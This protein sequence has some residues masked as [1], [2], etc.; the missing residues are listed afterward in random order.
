MNSELIKEL[1]IALK[2][3][4]DKN[5]LNVIFDALETFSPTIRKLPTKYITNTN[6]TKA[7]RFVNNRP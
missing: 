3:N 6:I 4:P 1:E 7:L 2:A 5:A